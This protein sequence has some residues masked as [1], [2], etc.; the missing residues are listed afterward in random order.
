MK[1]MFLVLFFI[2]FNYYGNPTS[3]EFHIQTPEKE[4]LKINITTMGNVKK[5]DLDIVIKSLEEFYSADIVL[6]PK[7]DMVKGFKVKGL[8]KYDARKILNFLE[9]KH[10]DKKHKVIMLTQYD[11][12]TDRELN[13][14]VNKNWGIFGLA[15]VNKKSCVVSTHRMNNN[16]IDRLTKVAIHEVGHTL[17]IPHCK[18]TKCIMTDAKGKGLTVDNASIW[19]CDSCNSKISY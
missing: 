6:L 12:C 14:V 2:L 7:T 19:M 9:E 10:Q 4:K 8:D 11:I 1:K 16:Y 17:G 15:K 5:S 13:G 18:N 3:E